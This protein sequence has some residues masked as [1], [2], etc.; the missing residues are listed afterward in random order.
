MCYSKKCT[1]SLVCIYDLKTHNAGFT[2]T[3]IAEKLQIKFFAD[4][5]CLYVREMECFS[6]MKTFARDRLWKRMA[7]VMT[8]D[9][10]SDV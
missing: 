8:W 4:V 6:S 10:V 2:L 3:L 7:S 5:F 9:D 1:F